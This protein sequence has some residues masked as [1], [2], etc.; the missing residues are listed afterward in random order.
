MDKYFKVKTV[1][2]TQIDLQI[3]QELSKGGKQGVVGSSQLLAWLAAHRDY[4][5]K[6]SIIDRPP[7]FIPKTE[8]EAGER[9]IGQILKP[10]HFGVLEHAHI[11]FECSGFPHS[12]PMQARTHRVAVTFDVQSQR[13]TGKRVLDLAEE[14]YSLP[15]RSKAFVKWGLTHTKGALPNGLSVTSEERELGHQFFN[16][17]KEVFYSRPPGE[18]VD[19]SGT[20]Y[21][22]R[23]KLYISRLVGNRLNS[24]LDYASLISNYGVSE[25]DARDGLAQ[26][27][28][29][30]FFVTFNIR[31]LMH[32]LDMRSK[33]DA[34]I[35]IRW[36]CDL[37]FEEFKKWTPEIAGWYEKK[38]LHKNKLAP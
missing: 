27:I 15:S 28:R 22:I 10:S 34:Q 17:L 16:K 38:R 33:A 24:V 23:E 19:R 5:E 13:Y 35:E 18:Y 3:L 21:N 36:L 9:L 7:S 31:S 8:T 25:E 2:K 29:Q 12:V 14:W 26:G 4:S 37:L 11:T 20:R 32:F 1:A 30:S 6:L